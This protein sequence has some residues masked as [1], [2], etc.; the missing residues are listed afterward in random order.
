MITIRRQLLSRVI[1]RRGTVDNYKETAAVASNKKE[2]TVDNFKKT[3][4]VASNKKEGT[5][6]NYKETAAVASNKKEGTVDNFK[7]TAAVASK[8]VSLVMEAGTSCDGA[9]LILTPKNTIILKLPKVM[10]TLTNRTP[11]LITDG[12]Q[13]SVFPNKVTAADPDRK[14]STSTN[15]ANPFVTESVSPTEFVKRML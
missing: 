1:R 5:V 12:I 3:A 10:M 6:D 14:D 4:A 2:G 9:E 7:K 15:S 13:G 8:P 11:G